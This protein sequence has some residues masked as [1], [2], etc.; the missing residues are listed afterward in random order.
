M[1]GMKKR[2]EAYQRLRREQPFTFWL[3]MF[4]MAFCLVGAMFCFAIVLIAPFRDVIIRLLNED[5]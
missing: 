2:R 3:A 1:G 5:F 4:S